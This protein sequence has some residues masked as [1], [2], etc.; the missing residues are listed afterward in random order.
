MKNRIATLTT[1]SVPLIF[2]A[3]GVLAAEAPFQ[4]PA[5]VRSY[6]AQPLL[7][8]AARA[9]RD[10]GS[11]TVEGRISNLWLY[12]TG[13]EHTVFA[14]YV[15]TTDQSPAK[16]AT[17]EKHLE[18][19]TLKADQIV[20]RRDLTHSDEDGALQGS[21]SAGGLDW[22]ASIGTGHVTGVNDK[23]EASTGAPASPD[24]TA[25]IGSGQAGK[26]TTAH[27]KVSEI[28]TVSQVPAAS[29]TPTASQPP[30]AHWTAKIGTA[31]AAS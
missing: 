13:D 5:T 29:Q 18:I 16:L 4:A 2:S 17:A 22:S 1:L 12:P 14:Q 11:R 31:H 24:W 27:S 25:S 15:V 7:Q 6:Q 30:S 26:G 8:Q 23:S 20:E 19:L 3:A 21:R 28:A 10:T 9:I